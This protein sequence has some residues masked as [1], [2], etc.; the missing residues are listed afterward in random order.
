M[1]ET[2][3]TDQAFARKQLDFNLTSEPDECT[4]TLGNEQTDNFTA[5]QE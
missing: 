4:L 3:G 5:A 2:Q 1:P